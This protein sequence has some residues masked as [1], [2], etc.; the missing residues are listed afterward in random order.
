[1]SILTSAVELSLAKHINSSNVANKI[2]LANE[3]QLKILKELCR[4]S[5]ITFGNKNEVQH[6]LFEMRLEVTLDTI[7]FEYIH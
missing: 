6:Q 3:Y 4:E 5:L 2:V 1:M 7:F